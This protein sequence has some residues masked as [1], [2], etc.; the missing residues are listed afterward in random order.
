MQH[1]DSHLPPVNARFAHP[2]TKKPM[3]LNMDRVYPFSVITRHMCSN[4]PIPV[5]V[6]L[7]FYHSTLNALEKQEEHDDLLAIGGAVKGAYMSVSHTPS[8][9]ED[10]EIA[11]LKRREFSYCNEFFAATMALINHDNLLNG[12]IDIPPDVCKE[13]GL[14]IFQG[15][16]EPPSLSADELIDDMER[17]NISESFKRDWMEAATQRGMLPITHY[18]ALPINHVLAWGLHVDEYCN[19]HKVI[20]EEFSYTP[21]ATV[22]LKTLPGG[23]S[24]ILL[25]YLIPNVCLNALRD[26]FEA[27]WM[28]KVDGRPFSSMG[29]EFIPMTMGGAAAAAAAAA[30]KEIKVDTFYIRSTFS[31]MIAPKLSREQ[32][33]NLAPTISP[34]FPSCRDWD[35]KEAARQR[36]LEQY[37][38]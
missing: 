32:I 3:E 7:N 13:A 25:Y 14:R 38:K 33:A 10:T 31:Y 2:Q 6:R 24:D 23:G 1:L 26:N 28:N 30:T 18:H 36:D 21:P 11:G 20:R 37:L 19:L 9:G 22:D 12:I 8:Y 29:V 16:P 35:P 4:V 15:P 5:A 34:T 17:M 27:V